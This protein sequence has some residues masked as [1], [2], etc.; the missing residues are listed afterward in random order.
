[1]RCRRPEQQPIATCDATRCCCG[2]RP[3]GA[4]QVGVGAFVLNDRREVLVVQERMGPLRFE[5]RAAGSNQ[6]WRCAC[7]GGPRLCASAGPLTPAWSP[8]QHN[9]RRACGRCPR[10]WCSRARTFQRRQN[11][12]ACARGPLV[13]RCRACAPCPLP[14]HKRPRRAC[15][16]CCALLCAAAQEVLEETGIRARFDGVLAMRQAHGFAFGKSDMFFVVALALEPGPQARWELERARAPGG[17]RPAGGSACHHT[18]PL[19]TARVQ[20]AVCSPG[21]AAL[22][23]GAGHAGG[24]AGGGALDATGGV[25]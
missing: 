13:C 19:C 7:G 24:G 15:C 25:L 2:P 22:P 18:L 5:V 17:S 6:P 4:V 8:P 3:P 10:G 14:R 1:M 9:M 21:C 11:G 16:A 20:R 12:C 23:A